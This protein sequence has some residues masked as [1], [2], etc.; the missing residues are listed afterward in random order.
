MPHRFEQ[1]RQSPLCL[2]QQGEGQRKTLPRTFRIGTVIPQE[3]AY[4][5]DKVLF[6]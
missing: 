1:D 6:W 2:G 3:S 5:A 4:S